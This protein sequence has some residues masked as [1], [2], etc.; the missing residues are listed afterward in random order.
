MSI[1]LGTAF[2][3]ESRTGTPACGYGDA[4]EGEDPKCNIASRQVGLT[5]D[6]HIPRQF[7]SLSE[8]DS[9]YVILAI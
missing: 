4:P 7:P 2:S 9:F 1:L 6:S 8:Y 5:H 3:S